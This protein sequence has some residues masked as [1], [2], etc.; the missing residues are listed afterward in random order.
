MYV[1]V[2]VHCFLG[3]GSNNGVLKFRSKETSG[4]AGWL[5]L[6]RKRKHFIIFPVNVQFLKFVSH[7][8]RN[9]SFTES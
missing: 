4:L 3:K 7:G 5:S 6:C 8:G 2:S 9:K 1:N